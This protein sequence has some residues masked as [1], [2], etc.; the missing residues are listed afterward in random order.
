MSIKH[1]QNKVYKFFPHKIDIY[2]TKINLLENKWG[3]IIRNGAGLERVKDH[4]LN[5]QK[6]DS[7][8]CQV[9][10][11]LMLPAVLI[12]LPLCSLLCHLVSPHAPCW[13]SWT[14]LML[15]AVLVYW[16][17]FFISHLFMHKNSI[18]VFLWPCGTLPWLFFKDGILTH[19]T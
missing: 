2:S 7:P 14:P 4:Y 6:M 19:T 13:A 3:T 12:D 10:T 8:L 1:Y 9:E 16:I 15:P 17:Y 5:F 11:L 18:F